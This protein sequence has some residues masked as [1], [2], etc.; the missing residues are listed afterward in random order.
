MGEQDVQVIE[1]RPKQQGVVSDVAVPVLQNIVVGGGIFLLTLT[2][3][4]VAT[5]SNLALM[6]DRQTVI[7]TAATGLGIVGFSLLCIVRG[8]WDEVDALL[9]R[10]AEH[11][12]RL[13][14]AEMLTDITMLIEECHKLEKE[15]GQLMHRLLV[16]E[17]PRKPKPAQSMRE[18]TWNPN[19]PDPYDGVVDSF[20]QQYEAT[21][22]ASIRMRQQ[23]D[24]DVIFAR[25][26]VSHYITHRT[27]A[28]H[29]ALKESRIGRREWSIA[30]QFLSDC[31]AIEKQGKAYVLAV[32]D[33]TQV[34]TIIEKKVQER[35]RI[36][37]SGV[38]TPA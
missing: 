11:R 2:I 38:H 32:D 25:K 7:F 12:N 15:K 31:G 17:P 22:A 19:D 3:G 13:D 35:A 6:F 26:L 30:T 20:V 21:G 10:Y 24:E 4:N 9:Y 18:V 1:T 14:V 28:K 27:F 33:M 36:R 16:A 37:A 29:S 5:H 8:A 23:P 34:E